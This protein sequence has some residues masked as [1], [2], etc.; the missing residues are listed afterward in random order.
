MTD[1]TAFLAGASVDA[2]VFELRPDLDA[3]DPMTD[4]DLHAAADDLIAHLGPQVR[5]ARRL[6]A[7]GGDR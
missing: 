2:A 4:E 1:R 5:S 6:I 3:L 7:A